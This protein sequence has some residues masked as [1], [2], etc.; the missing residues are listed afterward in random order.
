MKD[1]RHIQS[2]NEHG[3]NLNISDVSHS[4]YGEIKVGDAIEWG[5]EYFSGYDTHGGFKNKKLSGVNKVR[6]IFKEGML[7]WMELDNG[8]Q[9]IIKNLRKPDEIADNSW[10]KL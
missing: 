4:L 10:K 8:K 3:E 9:F 1:K 7:V 2:F 6:K 5:G